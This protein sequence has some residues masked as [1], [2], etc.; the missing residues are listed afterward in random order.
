MIS[1]LLINQS[2]TLRTK[3]AKSIITIAESL[4]TYKKFVFI[5]NI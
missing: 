2:W 3:A 4:G 5:F 1:P